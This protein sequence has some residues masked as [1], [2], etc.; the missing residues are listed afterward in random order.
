M[1]LKDLILRELLWWIKSPSTWWSIPLVILFTSLVPHLLIFSFTYN[2]CSI[3]ELEFRW[4]A[5]IN[6]Y[7]FLKGFILEQNPVITEMLKPYMD[8]INQAI[9][10]RSSDIWEKFVIPSLQAY[11]LFPLTFIIPPIAI[12]IFSRDRNNFVFLQYRITGGSSLKFLLGKIISI[13][14]IL[15]VVQCITMF[16]SHQLYA[17]LTERGDYFV[18]SNPKWLLSWGSGISLALL[19][20]PACWS[21]CLIARSEVSLYYTSLLLIP[22][23]FSLVLFSMLLEMDWTTHLLLSLMV[24]PL[25]STA[26]LCWPVAL[27]MNRETFHLK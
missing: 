24:L 13:F 27:K 11:N 8:D 1:N 18:W 7:K 15:L 9:Q 21:I 12:N 20:V 22:A 6:T 10:L 19:A 16:I 23:L 3:E 26:L 17:I 14:M 2:Y 25:V 4:D 5:S